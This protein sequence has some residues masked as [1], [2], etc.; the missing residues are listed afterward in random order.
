MNRDGEVITTR[1]G[2]RDHPGLRHELASRAFVVRTLQ[3][4]GLD[5]EPLRPAPGRPPGPQWPHERPRSAAPF[6]DY[7]GLKSRRTCCKRFGGSARCKRSA[8]ARRRISA[9][10][11]MTNARPAKR[12]GSNT[13]LSTGPCSYRLTRGPVSKHPR[14]STLAPAPW[15]SR[16]CC[17][18]RS[19]R[20]GDQLLIGQAA[21]AVRGAVGVAP[22]AM[23]SVRFI[24]LVVITG[25]PFG[26]GHATIAKFP[27]APWISV[28][29]VDPATAAI[30]I[31]ELGSTPYIE[32]S[33]RQYTRN[34]RL[35]PEQFRHSLEGPRRQS[36][37]GRGLCPGGSVYG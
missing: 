7:P 37:P 16:R 18:R 24:A 15:R 9:A 6:D 21:Q 8:V 27:L 23:A 36:G 5:V 33:C 29:E 2:V 19:T 28:T 17:R 12:G 1:Q 10:S 4:L 20:R 32:Y 25:P 11:A 30:S 14:M 35:L 13:R 3:K 31:L 26:D 34:A 22:P